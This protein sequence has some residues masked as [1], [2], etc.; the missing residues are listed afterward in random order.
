MITIA[1][2]KIKLKYY[3]VFNEIIFSTNKMKKIAL[4]FLTCGDLNQPKI[5]NKFIDSRYNIYNHCKHP[6][7]IKEGPLYNTQITNTIDTH[8]G[9]WTIVQATLNL[10]TE[11]LKNQENYKFVLISES[12][13]PICS[14]NEIYNF[15]TKDDHSYIYAYKANLERFNYLLDPAYISK[16]S[17]TKQSQWMTLN[18]ELA[19]FAVQKQHELLNYYKMFS[20]DEHFFVNLFLKYNL[21]FKNQ[22]LTFCDWSQN[23]F[24]PKEFQVLTTNQLNTFRKKGFLFLRKVSKTTKF[25]KPTRFIFLIIIILLIILFLVLL[26]NYL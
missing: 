20:P 22:E 17:F 6:E 16:D 26:I 18:R 25:V 9:T 1:L 24:H 21:P 8:W 12:C 7:K 11:A 19:S 10:L 23:E 4:L 5:W 3:W 2:I 15:L 13:I 14:S